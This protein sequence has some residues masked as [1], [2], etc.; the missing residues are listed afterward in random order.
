MKQHFYCSNKRSLKEPV[1]LHDK[2]WVLIIFTPTIIESAL[3]MHEPQ[4]LSTAASRIFL[5]N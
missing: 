5:K 2:K 1:F 3:T 4:L